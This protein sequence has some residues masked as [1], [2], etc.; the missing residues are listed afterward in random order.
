MPKANKKTAKREKADSS[1]DAE[2]EELL[3][4]PGT[5]AM[6]CKVR[7]LREKEEAQW[8]DESTEA[9]LGGLTVAEAVRGILCSHEI[10]MM[11][12]TPV[13]VVSFHIQ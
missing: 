2:C 1:S 9:N 6:Q 10:N 8:A 12:Q 11:L 3:Y 4:L 13:I 5:K 7:K